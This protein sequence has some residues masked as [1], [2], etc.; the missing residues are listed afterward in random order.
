MFGVS[1]I[2]PEAAIMWAINPLSESKDV[3]NTIVFRCPQ[4]IIKWSKVQRA[5]R[6]CSSRTISSYPMARVHLVKMVLHIHAE[7]SRGPIVLKPHST[8][9]MGRKF[10]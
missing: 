10:L 9:D 7:M 4:K 6:Q 8:S 2:S 1:S 3:A 5:R